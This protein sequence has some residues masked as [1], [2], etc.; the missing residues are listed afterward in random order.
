M[1]LNV[2][3]S[4]DKVGYSCCWRH[5]CSIC[6]GVSHNLGRKKKVCS[7][8]PTKLPWQIS[9]RVLHSCW[10][11]I[12]AGCQN[13]YSGVICGSKA[14]CHEEITTASLPLSLLLFLLMLCF[15]SLF[16]W[17]QYTP[18]NLMTHR[19]GVKMTN[20]LI[21]SSITEKKMSINWS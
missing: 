5:P 17:K 18:Y 19:S 8:F 2:F 4:W 20:G 10:M 16:P 15:L 7:I 12:V 1:V 9:N 6:R 21:L 11:I 14:E 3:C 13:Q